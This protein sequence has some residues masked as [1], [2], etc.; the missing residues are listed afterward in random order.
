LSSV[1]RAN[2]TGT[3]IHQHMDQKADIAVEVDTRPAVFY[4]GMDPNYHFFWENGINASDPHMNYSK[5]VVVNPSIPY[6][7]HFNKTA[8]LNT[9]NVFFDD[10]ILKVGEINR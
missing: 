10:G 7:S 1:N 5:Y 2:T 8:Y 9:I 6:P 4:Y 3:W